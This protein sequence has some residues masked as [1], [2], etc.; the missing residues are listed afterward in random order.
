MYIDVEGGEEMGGMRSRGEKKEEAMV[1][2]GQL[3]A[4]LVRGDLVISVEEDGANLAWFVSL[5]V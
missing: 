3:Q 2:K 5:R 4:P 1:T